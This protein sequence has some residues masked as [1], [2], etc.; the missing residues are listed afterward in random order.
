MTFV[1]YV[2][3]ASKPSTARVSFE[4]FMLLICRFVQEAL[5]LAGR[6]SRGVLG[7]DLFGL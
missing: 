4:Y 7:Q 2:P 6:E 1:V 3:A 5:V